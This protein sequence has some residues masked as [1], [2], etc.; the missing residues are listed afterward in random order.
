MSAKEAFR[1]V[2]GELYKR[3]TLHHL[4]PDAY[5]KAAAKPVNEKK[6]VFLEVRSKT[7]SD[8]F[9]L[10]QKA[11][12][13]Q[14]K[15]TCFACC[16]REGTT[17]RT[18]QR[19]LA[20]AAIELLADARYIFVN[21]SCYMLSSLPL[22]PETEVI[23]LWHACGAFKKFGY[24]LQGKLFG[25]GTEK[26]NTFPVHRNFTYVTVSS[27]EVVWAYAEAFHMEDRKEAILPVGV[28]RTDVFYDP[29]RIRAAGER[30]RSMVPAGGR[31]VLLYAPTF[32]GKVA[33]AV[34]PDKLDLQKMHREL[35]D[36]WVVVIKH[37]PFVRRRPPI[38]A[39]CRDFAF[40]LTD[41]MSIEEL[42]MAADVCMT[43]YSSLMFEYS[44][45]ERPMIFFAPD[46]GDY[47]GWRGFY[48]PYSSL[49]P[50][51]VVSKSEQVISLL[52]D[53]EHSF[54][55]EEVRAFRD[56]FMSACDGH[57]TERILALLKAPGED[58]P[59][60][61]APEDDAP[62]EDVPGENAP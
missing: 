49:T 40:D 54:N 11:L 33:M 46:L 48:Y 15:F 8:S 23:Q 18:S 19:K 47:D 5:A 56:K 16:I 37:H 25:V 1:G 42:L 55:M 28:S 61:D 21:D 50:G 3:W 44:L 43:D 13:E 27:P 7:L 39:S 24:S 26:L 41:Q 6:V 53:P 36:S 35:G 32:R 22:R 17:D 10:V 52:K 2:A 9:T 45:L 14:G 60:A 4:Y 31:K 34:S 62:A 30:L 38:P 29:E 58:M 20:L 57:A 59:E 12:Q 51:P